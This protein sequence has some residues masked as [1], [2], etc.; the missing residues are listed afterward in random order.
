MRARCQRTGNRPS[1]A[2][3]TST[4]AGRKKHGKSYF[5]YKVSAN[6]DKRYKLARKIKVGT[7]NEHDSPHSRTCSI[8]PT[9]AATSWPTRAMSMAN[10]RRAWADRLGVL[11]ISKSAVIRGV[12]LIDKDYANGRYIQ[13]RYGPTTSGK[14]ALFSTTRPGDID[15]P[16]IP[17]AR[18]GAAR[19]RAAQAYRAQSRR[20]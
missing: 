12:L 6:A 13:G 20:C 15:A 1:G 16:G 18:S 10:G 9:P 14:P 17:G 5:A 19:H 2:R 7:P 3:R 4:R 11:P 8:R